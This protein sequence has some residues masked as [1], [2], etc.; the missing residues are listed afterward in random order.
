MNAEITIVSRQSMDGECA[1]S[2]TT[3]Q[4]TLSTLPDGASLTYTTTEDGVAD[5]TCIA[6]EATRV[7]IDRRGSN[8]SCL[9][10]EP[11]QTHLCRYETPYGAF[12][13]GVTARLVTG[14]ITDTGGHLR[15][16]YELDMGGGTAT[17]HEIEITIKEVL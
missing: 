1:E 11:G 14:A 3:V 6:M 13:L 4:G 17:Q 7:T 9:V 5:T 2:V 16:A 8:R 12:S 15:L 10:L